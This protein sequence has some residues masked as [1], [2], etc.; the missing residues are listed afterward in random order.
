MINVIRAQL[1]AVVAALVITPAL[2]SPTVT[3]ADGEVAQCPCQYADSDPEHT[4]DLYQLIISLGAAYVC[5]TH[6][7]IHR[8]ANGDI[9]LE[10]TVGAYAS[11]TIAEA[12]FYPPDATATS[13]KCSTKVGGGYNI[14]FYDDTLSAQEALACITAINKACTNAGFQ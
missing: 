10:A 4:Q 1:T 5:S 6:P 3:R 12:Q 7:V 2:L 14:S 8:A 9:S 13:H 11:Q